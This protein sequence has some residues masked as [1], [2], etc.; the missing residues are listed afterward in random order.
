MKQALLALMWLGL[1]GLAH[2][3]APEASGLRVGPPEPTLERHVSRQMSLS[4]NPRLRALSERWGGRW[5]WRFDESTGRPYSIATAEIPWYQAEKLVEDL[6][7]TLGGVELERI[8][9]QTQGERRVLTY[10]QVHD[11]LPMFGTEVAVFSLSGRIHGVRL[12]LA[13]PPTQSAPSGA[14]M[15]WSVGKGQWAGAT[16]HTDSLDRVTVSHVDGRVLDR[17]TTRHHSVAELSYEERTVGD[18]AVEGPLVGATATDAAASV[19]TDATGTHSAADPYGLA[20]QGDTMVLEDWSVSGRPVPSWDEQNGDVLLEWRTDIDE[21]AADTWAHTQIV[22][23]WLEDRQPTHSLLAETIQARVNRGDV[24]CNAYYTGG[25]VNFARASGRCANTGR[26][27]DV[28]YHEYGHGVHHYGLL[29]GAF[30]GDLSEG[31]ADYISATILNDARVGLGFFGTGSVLRD[32]DPDRVYPTDFRGQVHND[33]RIWSS[34]LWNLRAD[35]QQIYGDELGARKVDRLMLDTMAQ[36][37]FLTTVGDAVI[38]ADDDDGDL[39]NGTP[40]ACALKDLLDQHGLGP[41]PLGVV[42]IEHE[43]IDTVGSYEPSYPVTFGLFDAMKDCSGLDRDTVALWY[44]TDEVLAEDA[45][46]DFIEG[47]GDL[48]APTTGPEYASAG[49]A[50]WTRLDL[51][52]V[53]DVYDGAIPRQLATTRVTYFI[54]ARSLEGGGRVTTHDGVGDGL[55]TFRVGDRE[56]VW[57]E[58]FETDEHGFEHGPGSPWE[59][60]ESWQSQWEFGEPSGEFWNP[61]AAFTGSRIVGTALDGTYANQNLQYLR[62]P[63]IDVPSDGRMLTFSFR[64]WLTVEDGF[65]DKANVYVDDQ[66]VWQQPV[67][68]DGRAHTLDTDWMLF[69]LDAEPYRGSTR[70]LTWTLRSDRGLEYGGWNLDDICVERLADLPGHHRVR[71]LTGL[72]DTTVSL[73]WTHPWIAPLDQLVVVRKR[74]GLPT[75][76]QDGWWVADRADVEPAAASDLVDDQVEPCTAYGYAVFVRGQAVW[77]DTVVEGENGIVLTT[78]CPE[79]P[80]TGAPDPVDPTP[81]GARGEVAPYSL[82]PIEGCGCRTADAPSGA[83]LLLLVLPWLRRRRT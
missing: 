41:G 40:H 63:E 36:G 13:Q 71:D 28:I 82:P 77:N 5:V 47:E 72:A 67:S 44:T 3:V 2:A 45:G 30:A 21:A 70:R 37:P 68:P 31:T 26:I 57:C 83:L 25:T 74:G 19:E 54:E 42:S 4:N 24:R 11:G 75:G 1:P 8:G 46:D 56:P 34:F 33:G 10:R 59:T 55:Y 76:I 14:Q 81:D 16:Q 60:S 64:R 52:A 65:F 73:A 58:S 43:P 78:D 22:R 9:V 20:L 32:I 61:D 49:G 53:A 48:A 27:A 7:Q 50:T 17:W 66:Q 38:L 18:A 39:S 29:S 62:S 23:A 80:D 69:E 15:W 35:W 79:E 6:R 12:A 51:N